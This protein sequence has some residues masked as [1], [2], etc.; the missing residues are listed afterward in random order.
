MANEDGV[1]LAEGRKQVHYM[2]FRSMDE[3]NDEQLRALLFEA[4]LIDEAFGRKKK[5]K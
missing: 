2:Y 3:I 4:G 5:L 1:L